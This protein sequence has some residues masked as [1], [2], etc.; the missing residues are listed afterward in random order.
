M[1]AA[2]LVALL[3]TVPASAQTPVKTVIYNGLS[4]TVSYSTAGLSSSEAQY[5]REMERVENEGSFVRNLGDLKRQYVASERALEPQRRRAQLASYSP[6]PTNIY[7]AYLYGYAATGYPYGFGPRSAFGYGGGYTAPLL[8]A[9]S[10]PGSA[11]A[12]GSYGSGVAPSVIK[13]AL[14]QAIAAQASP[15]YAASLEQASERVLARASDSPKLRTALHMA[16]ERKGR[17]GTGIRAVADDEAPVRLT[18]KNGD[19]VSGL[20][21]EEKG[22]WILVTLPGNRT[23]RLRESEVMRIETAPGKVAPAGGE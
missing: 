5:L 1:R 22:D 7:P 15:E 11:L 9:S 23:L 16:P 12:N 21:M 6:V 4:R 14:A 18:L 2:F 19:K 10:A 17:P 8:A 3:A 13:E 20:K